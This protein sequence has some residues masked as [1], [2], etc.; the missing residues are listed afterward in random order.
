MTTTDHVTAPDVSQAQW[1]AAEDALHQPQVRHSRMSPTVDLYTG[2]QRSYEVVKQ[3][4]FS[5]SGAMSGIF[6]NM[7]QMSHMFFGVC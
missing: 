4:S 1:V 6:V 7:T 3:T 5:A 2:S